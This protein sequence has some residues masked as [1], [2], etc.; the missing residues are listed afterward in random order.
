MK[1][2]WRT[3]VIVLASALVIGATWL[4]T[5]TGNAGFEGRRPPEGQERPRREG[6][7]GRPG[8]PRG[9]RGGGFNLFGA[10]EVLANLLL[11]GIVTAIVIGVDKTLAKRGGAQALAAEDA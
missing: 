10:G 4:L 2:L 6:G 1:T 11:T 3:L 9:E 5:P 8:G 7:E